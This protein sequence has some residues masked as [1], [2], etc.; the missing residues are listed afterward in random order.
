MS[1]ENN[2]DPI[3]EFMRQIGFNSSQRESIKLHVVKPIEVRQHLVFYGGNTNE[4]MTPIEENSEVET[5]EDA[6]TE[7]VRKSGFN[8]LEPDVIKIKKHSSNYQ[9]NEILEDVEP[10]TPVLRVSNY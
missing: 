6:L 8:V 4:N 3:T 1:S 5:S 7:F 9:L 2:I 10:L